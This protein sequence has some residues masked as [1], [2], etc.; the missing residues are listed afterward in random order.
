M[1]ITRHRETADYTVTPNAIYRDRRL[2]YRALGLLLYLLHLPDGWETD[3]TQLA[4]DRAE[5]RDAIRTALRQLQDAG[6]VTRRRQQDPE[7]GQWATHMT[8]QSHPEN[9]QVT[10]KTENQAPDTH[11]T[12]TKPHV[13]PK[14]DSQS[15]EIQSS[16]TRPS[17][18]QALNQSTESKYYKSPAAV[19]SPTPH[20][21]ARDH[22]A[23]LNTNAV[24]AHAFQLL[25]RWHHTIGDPYPGETLTALAR[26][27]AQLLTKYHPNL[28]TEA[29]NR[30]TT[31][32]DARPGLLPHLLTDI[33]KEQS[34]A[35]AT[36]H[37]GPR[38]TPQQARGTR[39]DKVRGWLAL[40]EEIAA[41]EAAEGP[42]AVNPFLVLEGGM[43]A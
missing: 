26:P 18:N 31:R 33:L 5:G 42:A 9:P 40:G 27:V 16:G 23:Q 43:S 3:S 36:L 32:T 35:G 17:V 39:G 41:Q 8:V 24:P 10:P 29:L 2:S 21:S 30:W 38:A 28:I 25:T 6:Y 15:S 19:T 11:P 34:G 22:A 20:A 13:T 12:N 37:T 7:T 14:T 1:K 4:T